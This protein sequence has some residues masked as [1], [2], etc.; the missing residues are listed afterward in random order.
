MRR[1]LPLVLLLSGC[2]LAPIAGGAALGWLG[3]AVIGYKD[4]GTIL[5][6]A[7]PAVEA[8]CFLRPWKPQSEEAKAAIDAF[9]VKPAG[10]VPEFI[11]QQFRIVEAIDDVHSRKEPR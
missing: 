11:A 1:L 6:D 7:K 4:A 9:C 5:A 3:A 10:T 8:A 2:H